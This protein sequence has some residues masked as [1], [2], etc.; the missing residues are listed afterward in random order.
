MLR[1]PL[2]A[3]PFPMIGIVAV[4]LLFVFKLGPEFMKNRKPFK[5]NGLIQVYNIIQVLYCFHLVQQSIQY[6]YLRGYSLLCEPVDFSDT[7]DGVRI[8]RGVYLYWLIKVIDL[9]DTVFFILRKKQNQVTF[10]HV[11]HHA[12]MVA[13]CWHGAKYFPGGHSVFMGTINSFVH[14]VMY[15]YYFLTSWNAEY[16]KNIWWKKYITQLQLI[17]FFLIICHFGVLLFQ[18]NCDFPKFSAALM[19]PQN[20]FM[21]ILFGDFYRKAYMKKKVTLKLDENHNK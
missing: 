6:C 18:S 5:L 8:A 15:S 21:L 17:Q 9:L 10:L 3:N 14:V 20:L 2:M 12:G 11:Y 7:I 16:K 4:Y 19:I 1:F 13:L